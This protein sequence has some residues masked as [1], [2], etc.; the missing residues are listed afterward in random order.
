MLR[1]IL[2]LIIVVLSF[3]SYGQNQSD[4]QLVY[5]QDFERPQAM[6]NFDLT[7]DAAWKIS[8]I[9][10]NKSLELYQASQYKIDV[11]SP[12]NIALLRDLTLG[13]FVMEVEL[14]QTGREYG[15]RD[16]CLFFGFQNPTNFYYVHLGSVADQNANNIFIVNDEPRRNIA[17]KTSSGTKW[18]STDSWHK[19]KIE[20][21]V[22]TGT[23]RIY[24]DDMSSPIMEA[25]DTHFHWGQVGL[26]SFDD[27]GKFDNLTIYAPSVSRLEKS[28]FKG[29]NSKL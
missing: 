1:C 26:G 11:R 9:K 5:I 21:N 29:K 3:Y 6:G 25:T 4:Y 27:T 7:D 19:A 20:R 28:V 23:I 10:G 12:F 13:S 24:F 8:G 18:G 14:S 15:H 16:L 22:E 17:T 2:F